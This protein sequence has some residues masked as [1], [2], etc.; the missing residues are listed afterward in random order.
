MDDSNISGISASKI[1]GTI[2]VSQTSGS[3]QDI[4]SIYFFSTNNS[5][6]GN[7]GGRAGADQKCSVSIGIYFTTIKSSC[8]KLRDLISVN[9]D[10]SVY[11]MHN[12]YSCQIIIL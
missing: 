5:F 6:T 4:K 2:P 1:I 7:L 10:D 9:L 8:T 3:N 12:N 11:V